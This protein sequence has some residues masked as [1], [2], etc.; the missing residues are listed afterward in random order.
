MIK[1][2]F[3]LNFAHELLSFLIKTLSVQ[4]PCF[5]DAQV[6]GLTPIFLRVYASK[7]NTNA[8]TRFSVKNAIIV[9]SVHWYHVTWVTYNLM[10]HQQYNNRKNEK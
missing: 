2:V 5:C 3:L 6:T 4:I 9:A 1:N 7:R 10:L 8:S